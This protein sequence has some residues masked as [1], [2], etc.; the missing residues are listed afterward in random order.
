MQVQQQLKIGLIVESELASSFTYE[1]AECGRRRSNL[2]ISHLI[3]QKTSQAQNP[4]NGKARLNH[5]LARHSFDLLMK[6]ERAR[7]SHAHA[8]KGH[9]QQY[10]LR[11]VVPKCI[12]V[13]PEVSANGYRYS[14]EDVSLIRA[15]D[16][17]LIILCGVGLLRGEILKSSKLGI[18][19]ALS[20]EGG[21][22]QEP[23]AGF[24]EV[25]FQRDAT[26][27][28][29]AR[30]TDESGS[31]ILMRALLPTKH[32]FLLNQA[33]LCRRAAYYFLGLLNEIAL[34]RTLPPAKGNDP[35]P[36]DPYKIPTVPGQF[37]YVSKQVASIGRNLVARFLFRKADR[38][39]LAFARSD[40]E[41]LDLSRAT[42][43]K[44]P[45]NHFL[46]DPFVVTHEGRDFCFT[47]DYDYEK[48]RGC[49]AVYELKENTAERL[50]EAIVEPFHM[51]F[52]YLF[53]FEGKLYMC[54]E[55]SENRDIRVYE[56]TSFP[57]QW[58]LAKVLMTD[59]DA[60]DTMIFEK[61]GL[62]WLFTN[63]DPLKMADF[64]SELRCFYAE[65]PLTSDWTPHKKNPILIDSTKG[66]NGGL[67]R[68]QD[69]I[70]RVAQRQ[71]F[72][73]YGKSISINKI[74]VLTKED[75]VERE[76]RS[77]EPNFFA[78]IEGIHHMHSNNCVLVFDC[79]EITTTS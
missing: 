79:L 37:V 75:Y 40:W 31:D 29:I 5:L 21:T 76:V 61:D 60:V 10:D 34:T 9:F 35:Y 24:W 20:T 69:S 7:L 57:L 55:T 50:G 2:L 3:I 45:T 56:C 38:W 17:D 67:L 65:S 25:Y 8:Y 27:F 43:I 64:S 15:L 18:L 70:H 32:Y 53:R 71:G 42:R 4:R 14:E 44:N 30:L 11:R 54:P 47:E 48:E 1:L 22:I 23:S 13:E 59:I 46:A 33:S 49:I 51:S 19:A 52:P 63:I 12:Y 62:W 74:E 58:T 77:V 72:G 36:N 6:A 66:R 26:E 73:R 41:T 68:H 39:G 28:T 16:L 78:N